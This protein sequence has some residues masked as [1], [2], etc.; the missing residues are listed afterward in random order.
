MPVKECIV[1]NAKP[2]SIHMDSAHQV[3]EHR[4]KKKKLWCSQV[5]T[6]S[7]NYHAQGYVPAVILWEPRLLI[8]YGHWLSR[9]MNMVVSLVKIVS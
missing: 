1:T 2:L 6:H 4:L 3:P 7:N 8:L 5:V 9:D